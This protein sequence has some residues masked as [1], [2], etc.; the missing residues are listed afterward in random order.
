MRSALNEAGAARESARAE[1]GEA[2]REMKARK[3]L[4]ISL[5]TVSTLAF[6][7][8]S[9]GDEDFCIPFGLEA[10]LWEMFL[11]C[12]VKVIGRSLTGTGCHALVR[13][14][15]VFLVGFVSFRGFSVVRRL[16][17]STVNAISLNLPA[18]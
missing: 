15:V 8:F 9:P 16:C 3:I 12:R 6:H 10:L 2:H 14:W 4:V 5:S 17:T 1:A 11:L 18:K 13:V 7:V